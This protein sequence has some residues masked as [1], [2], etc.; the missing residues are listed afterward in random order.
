MQKFVIVT[1]INGCVLLQE[2]VNYNT[3]LKGAVSAVAGIIYT[4]HGSRISGLN[5]DKPLDETRLSNG[6]GLDLSFQIAN[7]CE[8]LVPPEVI[9]SL[10]DFVQSNSSKK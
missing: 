10:K 7:R 9:K 5:D 3:V 2:K 8:K 6:I 4:D 1:A